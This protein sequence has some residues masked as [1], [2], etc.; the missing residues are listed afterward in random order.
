MTLTID[1]ETAFFSAVW[2]SVADTQPRM[3]EFTAYAPDA[4]KKQEMYRA[5]VFIVAQEI[6]KPTRAAPMQI[7]ICQVRSLNFPD[8]RPMMIPKNPETRYGGHVS[9]NVTVRL[10]PRLPTTVGKKLLKLHAERCIFCMR[11][12]R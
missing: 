6:M 12:R 5:A 8:V 10:K 11:Q 1:K 3:T 9:A 2:P 4:N 7:V